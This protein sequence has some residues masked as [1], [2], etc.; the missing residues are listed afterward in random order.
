[1][2]TAQWSPPECRPD[3][4]DPTHPTRELTPAECAIFYYRPLKLVLFPN[5]PFNGNV[6]Y[7][8]V[9]RLIRHI[10]SYEDELGIS[11]SKKVVLGPVSYEGGGIIGSPDTV[12]ALGA[13]VVDL[14]DIIEKTRATTGFMAAL[15]NTHLAVS[16]YFF[17]IVDTVVRKALKGPVRIYTIEPEEIPPYLP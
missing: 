14:P 11:R 10:E 16:P 15:D 6:Y 5:R 4:T 1:M 9:A 7:D 12:M 2:M 13:G 3:P 8:D 17:G